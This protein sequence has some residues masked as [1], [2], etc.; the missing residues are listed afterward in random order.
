MTGQDQVQRGTTLTMTHVGS[1][2][3]LWQKI[4]ADDEYRL[5]LEWTERERGL[6]DNTQ[7]LG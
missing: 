2:G 3:A 1:F 5:A 6:A 7:V 4:L